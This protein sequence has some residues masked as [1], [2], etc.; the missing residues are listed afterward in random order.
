[1]FHNVVIA[2]LC[3]NNYAKHLVNVKTLLVCDFGDFPIGQSE[4]RKTTINRPGP[5]RNGT[6]GVRRVW[7]QATAKSPLLILCLQSLAVILPAGRTL[8]GP[9]GKFA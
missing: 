2:T 5:L 8:Q 6:P 4:R 9:E 1:L 3:V 7:D